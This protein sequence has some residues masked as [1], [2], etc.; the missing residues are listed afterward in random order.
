[1]AVIDLLCPAC[2]A[3]FLAEPMADRELVDCLCGARLAVVWRTRDAVT[4]HAV[5][6]LVVGVDQVTV[7]G[8]G[9]GLGH[10]FRQ[11]ATRCDCGEYRRNENESE[12]GMVRDPISAIHGAKWI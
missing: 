12:R 4:A 5:S 3:S 2:N 9:G 11:D 10:L 1:V 8:C 6:C 7:V